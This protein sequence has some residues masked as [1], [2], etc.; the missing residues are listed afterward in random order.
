M[1]HVPCAQGSWLGHCMAQRSAAKRGT[2]GG[3]ESFG[4]R[5][6]S[7]QLVG[8]CVVIGGHSIGARVT[9]NIARI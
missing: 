7:L 5:V 4:M 6:R 9:W 8:H 2:Q 3:G 1:C